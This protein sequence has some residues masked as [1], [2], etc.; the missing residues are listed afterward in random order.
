MPCTP[1]PFRFLARMSVGRSYGA[2]DRDQESQY[3]RKI[4][5]IFNHEF[6]LKDIENRPWV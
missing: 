4:A 1:D 5:D 6:L 3:H 2:K